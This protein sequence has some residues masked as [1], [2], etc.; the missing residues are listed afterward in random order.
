MSD[1]SSAPVV[2][3]AVDDEHVARLLRHNETLILRF[4]ASWCGPCKRTQDAFE[5][6]AHAN[7]SVP[8]VFVDVDKCPSTA[9]IYKVTS[10]PLHCCIVSGAVTQ[11]VQSIGELRL[12]SNDL[13]QSFMDT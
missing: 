11:R 9:L 13:A 3:T 5:G 10:I 8:C 1:D 4:T 2:I 7:P 6:W 12:P